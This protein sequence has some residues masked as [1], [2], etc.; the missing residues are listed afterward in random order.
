LVFP[1]GL[2]IAW[3]SI[4]LAKILPRPDSRHGSLRMSLV[5]VQSTRALNSSATLRA[6][7]EEHLSD[8]IYC[9]QL[10]AVTSQVSQE[11]TVDQVI[12][13][14]PVRSFSQANKARFHVTMS[15]AKQNRTLKLELARQGIE[16]KKQQQAVPMN[17]SVIREP[18]RS[19]KEQFSTSSAAWK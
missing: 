11:K 6:V 18:S 4:T 13:S 17:G 12:A 19:L 5:F 9:D 14:A 2:K 16:P 10:K 8:D 15:L 3:Q 1:P 7:R